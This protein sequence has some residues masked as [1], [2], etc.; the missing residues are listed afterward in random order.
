MTSIWRDV[1]QKSRYEEISSLLIVFF[2]RLT[3][4]RIC[5]G[6]KRQTTCIF[7][8]RIKIC[9]PYIWHTR[10]MSVMS[11]FELYFYLCLVFLL[12][13]YMTYTTY[14]CV[15]F[16]S[17]VFT[18]CVYDIHDI[19]LSC[20][21]LEEPS[22]YISCPCNGY[23]FFCMMYIGLSWHTNVRFTNVSSKII[24]CH[25]RHDT[26]Q[27]DMTRVAPCWHTSCIIFCDNVSDSAY[28]FFPDLRV[29]CR[30]CACVYVI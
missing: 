5:I 18:G 16:M 2:E 28:D 10:Y 23:L 6:P 8:Y 7:L 3:L 17:C 26:S 30:I 14:V 19:R 12:D 4:C 27:S 20:Q 9:L 1:Y 15:F 11:T 22:G 25:K 29:V 13:V 21:T 24:N